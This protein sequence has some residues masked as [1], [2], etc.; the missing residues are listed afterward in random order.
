[1]VMVMFFSFFS[2]LLFYISLYWIF[3]LVWEYF[4]Q[5]NEA[6]QPCV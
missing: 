1:M 5:K 6:E 3:A 2:D 4:Q